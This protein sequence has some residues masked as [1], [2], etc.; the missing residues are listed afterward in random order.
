MAVP[1]SSGRRP[2]PAS[3]PYG[4]LSVMLANNEPVFIQ[5]IDALVSEA[6]AAGV[7]VHCDAVQAMDSSTRS[8]SRVLKWM[9]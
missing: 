3:G 6:R 4:V 9:Q 7:V 2:E 5:P 8:T 1:A